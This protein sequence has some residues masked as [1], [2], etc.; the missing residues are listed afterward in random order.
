LSSGAGTARVARPPS[1]GQACLTI[2]LVALILPLTPARTRPSDTTIRIGVFG[3]FHPIDL[4][5]RP[6]PGASLTIVA[7]DQTLAIE[8]NE[9]AKLQLAD[10]SIELRA[11]GR[12]VRTAAIHASSRSGE[13]ELG[14]PGRIQRRFRGAL[15]VTVA[16]E[17]LQS[18]VT[19]DLETA[20]ASVVAAESPPD[21][22]L[23]ALKAQAVAARSYFVA[24]HGRH[25]GFD[26]CDTTHCQFLREAPPPEHPAAIATAATRGMV[27]QHRDHIVP[28][29]YSASC[30][31]RTHTL[32]ELG[33]PAADYPYYS[34]DCAYCRRHAETW[35][36]SLDT[37]DAL[38]LLE[39]ETRERSRLEVGRRLGW[40]TVPGNNFEAQQEGDAV[41]LRGRGVGHGL[42]L[43]QR[44]AADMAA[45]GLGFRAILDH[46]YVNTTLVR[47]AEALR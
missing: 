26:F 9:N 1:A 45:R 46:Y 11:R 10:G 47:Q 29:Y 42:G 22:P 18:V 38:P 7:G 20:V 43:C 19:M 21:A 16:H 32:A 44:G 40:S 15:Q 34:V 31:G 5:L 28:A 25:S 23:E 12:V 33:L 36:R 3:L 24:N 27:L 8:G 37:E 39:E 17:E 30:G 41:V 35:E 4:E 13:F 2:L 6:A 14:V